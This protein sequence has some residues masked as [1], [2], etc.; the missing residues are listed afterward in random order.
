MESKRLKFE[1]LPAFLKAGVYYSTKLEATRKQSYYP[2][3]FAFQLIMKA[4]TQEYYAGQE[5]SA[6]RKFEEAYSIWRYF[7]SNN[8]KWANEGIDDTQLTEEEFQ[9][10]DE[11][12]NE[13]IRQHKIW[14]LQSICACLLKEENYVDAL[15]V[16]NEVLRLDPNN[17]VGL[18]RRAKAI[19]KPVNASVE[20]YEQAI[21]DLKKI[22]SNEERILKEI[23]RLREQ[24][25]LNRK[26]E[27][28]T[29]GKM[30][31]RDSALRNE[32][33]PPAS[34]NA[35]TSASDDKAPPPQ[36]QKKP[37]K[38]IESITEYLEKKH[39]KPAPAPL[40]TADK[41]IA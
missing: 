1:R 4:A 29:Y 15:P 25:T 21:A 14:S 33:D 22:N 18:I 37:A 32:V 10:K 12:E 28:Q 31:F 9:T 11:Q 8:P 17:R 16:A 27:R 19:S 23:K 36:V 41:E 13:W 39:P 40:S 38:P 7:K 30:F 26:R 35:T 2:R 24:A 6:C 34:Q 5:S 3:L 20:D